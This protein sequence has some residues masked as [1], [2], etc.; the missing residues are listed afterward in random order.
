MLEAAENPL[1]RNV[2]IEHPDGTK[3]AA[4]AN[5]VTI[6][7]CTDAAGVKHPPFVGPMQFDPRAQPA[8]KSEP[9]G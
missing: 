2:Q 7:A 9:S 1:C 6:Q 4:W 3:R 8:P 5:D